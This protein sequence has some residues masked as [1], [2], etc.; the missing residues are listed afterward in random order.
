VSTA[1]GAGAVRKAAFAIRRVATGDDDGD[2]YVVASKPLT[3][4]LM[5]GAMVMVMVVLGEGKA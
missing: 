1:A 3:L 2:G 5:M 4:D